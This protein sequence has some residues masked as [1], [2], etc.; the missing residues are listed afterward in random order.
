MAERP[1]TDTERVARAL[2]QADGEYPDEPVGMLIDSA[3]QEVPNWRRYA[4]QAREAIG[5]LWGVLTEGI[6]R[7]KYRFR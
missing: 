1:M 4:D 6:G 3:T 2:C 5:A 7:L